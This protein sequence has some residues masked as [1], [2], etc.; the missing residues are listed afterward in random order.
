MARKTS[1]NDVSEI[2]WLRR[3]RNMFIVFTVIDGRHVQS[4]YGGAYSWVNSKTRKTDRMDQHFWRVAVLTN[5][6]VSIYTLSPCETPNIPSQTTKNHFT[7]DILYFILQL[8]S[9]LS[10]T[11]L[12][13]ALRCWLVCQNALNTATSMLQ[14]NRA[15]FHAL[16]YNAIMHKSAQLSL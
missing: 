3:I 6:N 9:C 2:P 12:C 15:T 1:C 10:A 16:L 13:T 4:S 8:S 11:T 5:C 14:R 7:H